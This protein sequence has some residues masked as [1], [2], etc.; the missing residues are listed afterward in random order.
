MTKKVLVA[1]PN[2]KKY[3]PTGYQMLLDKGYDVVCTDLD[4]DYFLEELLPLVGDIDGCIANCEP[5]GEEAMS[6]API[7]RIWRRFFCGPGAP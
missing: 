5:W 4:R 1:K 7:H 2:Y 6:A 3:S